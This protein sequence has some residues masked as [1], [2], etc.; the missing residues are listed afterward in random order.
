MFFVDFVYE[1]CRRSISAKVNWVFAV[2]SAN[3]GYQKSTQK[4]SEP[5]TPKHFS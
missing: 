2:K 1:A 3:I 4:H 5:S